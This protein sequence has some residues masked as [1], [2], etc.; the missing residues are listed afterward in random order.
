MSSQQIMIGRKIVTSKKINLKRIKASKI[1]AETRRVI[2][3]SQAESL[4]GLL[5]RDSEKVLRKLA[6]QY[7]GIES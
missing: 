2:R 3:K 4:Q 6:A 7:W 5:G 1:S